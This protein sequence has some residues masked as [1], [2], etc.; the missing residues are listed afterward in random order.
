MSFAGTL[1]QTAS[2]V[3][4]TAYKMAF[5]LS[6]IV[7]TNGIANNMPGKALP[8]IVFTE[9]INFVDGLLSG[10]DNIELDNFFANFEPVTGAT[11]IDQQIGEYPFA[12]QAVAANATIAQPLRVSM[13][14]K[15][16]A[17]NIAGYTV[18]LATMTALQSALTQH[19]A[20]GGTYTVLTP[21]YFYTNCIMTAMRDVSS[22]ESNQYQYIWQMDFEK[23]LLTLEDAQAAQSSLMSKIGNQ[24]KIEGQPAWSSINTAFGDIAG[25]V[26]G[27]IVPA[28]KGVGAA[29]VGG[30]SSVANGTLP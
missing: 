29:F 30:A 24:T 7:L 1:A 3:A 6:P 23:P 11:L 22:G 16:P 2:G 10:T 15:C 4:R 5:Q 9:A 8:I 27:Q 21:S 13:L 12:N 28:A 26:T 25:V 14:M 18:K 19:N 17:R 20:S